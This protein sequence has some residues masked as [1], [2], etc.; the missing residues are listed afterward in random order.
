M[1]YMFLNKSSRFSFLVFLSLIILSGFGCATAPK[2]VNDQVSQIVKAVPAEKSQLIFLNPSNSIAGA[3]FSEVYS[4]EGSQRELLGM[5]GSK[6]KIV[7]DVEPGDHMFMARTGLRSHFMKAQGLEA[8][9]R[10][11]VLMR[12]IYG[13]GMQLR[14]IRN[15]GGSDYSSSNTDFESWKSSTKIVELLPTSK[16][17]VEENFKK[18]VEES[19]KKYWQE[20]QEKSD[21]QRVELTLT[22]KDALL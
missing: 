3:F 21:V 14:P 12:F 13:A 19:Y 17:Y 2:L 16:K 11:Y 8:G 6:M 7:V 15:G 20:W 4:L 5:A 10:Y 1:K 18:Y 9:K 22:A